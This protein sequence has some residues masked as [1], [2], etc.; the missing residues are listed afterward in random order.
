MGM[1]LGH[2]PKAEMQTKQIVTDVQLLEEAVDEDMLY[3]RDPNDVA[4]LLCHGLQVGR[5]RVMIVRFG[6]R[7]PQRVVLF[8]F[9]KRDQAIGK[10]LQLKLNMQSSLD[11]PNINIGQ[12]QRWQAVLKT[13]IFS[14]I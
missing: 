3:I 7:D 9:I 13:H 10:I 6:N 5:V 12:Y 2:L 8:G 1:P 4:T 14:H 11:A